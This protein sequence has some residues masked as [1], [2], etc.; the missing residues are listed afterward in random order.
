MMLPTLDEFKQAQQ[1]I[2]ALLSKTPLERSERLSDYFKADVY[3]KRE[4]LQQVRS[5]KIR[6]AFNKLLTL[7]QESKVKRVICASAGN[8][9]QGVA[10]S[11]ST[12]NVHRIVIMPKTT[13]QQKISKVH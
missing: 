11:C 3:L 13:P 5:Y 2:E 12:L 8:H 9:A 6:G 10:L 1:R 4:D 7:S